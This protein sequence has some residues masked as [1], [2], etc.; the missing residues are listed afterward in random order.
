[1]NAH[2]L[3]GDLSLALLVA[4][5]EPAWAAPANERQFGPSGLQ[6]P[7]AAAPSEVHSP[8]DIYEVH[9]PAVEELPDLIETPPWDDGP[10]AM[11][12]CGEACDEGCKCCPHGIY[13]SGW[14]LSLDASAL[15][16]HMASRD[17]DSWPND[18]A[19]AGRITLGYE[20]ES[21]AGI[22]AQAWGY[23][24]SGLSYIYDPFFIP[25]AVNRTLYSSYSVYTDYWFPYQNRHLYPYN[26][27]SSTFAQE[28]ELSMASAYID[29]YKTIAS[30]S[31]ELLVGAG[32]AFGHLEF[33]LP[34]RGDGAKYAGGGVTAFGQGLVPFVRRPSWGLAISGQA[35]ITLLTGEWEIERNPVMIDTTSEHSE[36]MSIV[37]LGVGP[38]FRRQIGR[39][40]THYW[41]VRTLAE[42]QQ[43][44]SDRMGPMAG[45]TLALQGATL[46][47][48]VNW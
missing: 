31:S 14:T 48:G 28:I 7:T 19:P 6:E 21:G 17:I 30:P 36:S 27:R 38:E 26:H 5:A 9:E 25:G 35:R 45:D 46:N 37:E 24:V 3:I 20:T 22:R 39:S 8:D 11:S 18:Y 34:P 47:F 41:F 10:Q 33:N 2:K 16:S 40:G 1:M 15:Q 12:G 4:I 43:W 29:F 32:P 42:F 44:R 23:G 13:R